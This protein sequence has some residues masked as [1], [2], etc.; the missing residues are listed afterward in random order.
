MSN[1]LVIEDEESIRRVLRR[2]LLDENSSYKI[3]EANAGV[4]GI[5][6]IK[7]N[8]SFHDDPTSL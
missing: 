2:V 7:K 4:S 6:S 1:I 3:L 5:E 8:S